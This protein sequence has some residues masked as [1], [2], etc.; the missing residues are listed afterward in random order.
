M[1]KI[2]SFTGDVLLSF[3][4]LGIILTAVFSVISLSPVKLEID[5]VSAEGNSL[6]L[7]KQNFELVIEGAQNGNQFIEIKED[8]K[9]DRLLRQYTLKE[10][11]ESMEID[12]ASVE[13]LTKSSTNYNVE[14]NIPS[15]LRNLF[16]ITLLLRDKEFEL[17]ENNIEGKIS[18]DIKLNGQTRDE[19]KLLVEPKTPINYPVEFEAKIQKSVSTF[20]LP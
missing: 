7:G 2:F 6:V 15:D 3:L 4:L 19:I 9:V 5:D 1:R 10:I 11:P 12:F 8:S 16:K 18:V 13:N 20:K 14:L 17:A